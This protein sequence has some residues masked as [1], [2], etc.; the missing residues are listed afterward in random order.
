VERFA[1]TIEA[2]Y[3][4]MIEISRKRGQPQSFAVPA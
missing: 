2:A 4:R 3:L 1:R